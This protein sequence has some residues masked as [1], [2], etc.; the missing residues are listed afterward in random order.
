MKQATLQSFQILK[1]ES[2]HFCKLKIDSGIAL[3]FKWNLSFYLRR[4]GRM[5]FVSE[6]PIVEFF[7]WDGGEKSFFQETNLWKMGNLK[8]EGVY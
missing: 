7:T 3:I 5:E 2:F 4:V 1:R 8:E 6:L